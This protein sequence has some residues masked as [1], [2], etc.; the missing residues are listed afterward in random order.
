LASEGKSVAAEAD[1]SV[2][3]AGEL[4]TGW[5]GVGVGAGL[6]SVGAAFAG[7]AGAGL[8]SAGAG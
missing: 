6:G 4:V 5:A 1:G 7:V 8:A 2:P 3:G